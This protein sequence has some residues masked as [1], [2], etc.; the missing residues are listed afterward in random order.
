MC[1]STYLTEE[2]GEGVISSPSGPVTWHLSVGLDAG[3][4]VIELSAGIAN[5]DTSLANMDGDSF[6][7]GCCLVAAEQ[8]ARR[9]R[10]LLLLAGLLSGL[11]KRTCLTNALLTKAV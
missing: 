7:H 6:M 5:L 1:A 4:Q 9:K 8:K 3:F 11:S 10:R 2:G